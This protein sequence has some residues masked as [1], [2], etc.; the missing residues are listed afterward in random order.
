M[1]DS[2]IDKF[3]SVEN[4]INKSE[5][6]FIA[7]HINPDGDNIGSILAMGLALNSLG[8]NVNVLKTDT[9][10][11]DFNFLPG[12][13][14]IKDFKDDMDSE[15]LFIVLDSSDENRLGSLKKLLTIS[16]NVINIDH[17]I[18]NTD[19]GKINVV[20][21]LACAT[22]EIVYRLLNYMNI[23]IDKD[24]ATNIY[25]AISTDSGSFKYE[26]VTGDTH[27]IIAKLLDVGIDHSSI[28][29]NLYE[30]M[31]I[32]R[33]KLINYVLSNLNTYNDGKIAVVKVN[34]EI[35]KNTNTSME[36]TESIVSYIRKIDTVEVACILKEFEP[37]EIKV[38]LRSK[39]Y[40]D[41]SSI[42]K[43][44]DGGGHKR[45]A[46][47]KIEKNIDETEAILIKE[48]R[49]YLGD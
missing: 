5:N 6:I 15:D 12:I 22:G 23:N 13:D 16:K 17:H 4:L 32:G 44:F 31:S 46:G 20:D 29:L 35:L 40:V 47:C 1:N 19:F 30:K 7:S 49:N 18:S 3:K 48:I 34:D 26:S 27:R 39:S 43:K 14:L 37:Q 41:V 21:P 36:D 45:A 24:I 33:F 25:T 2:L 38:S 42:C 11:N 8:K 9:I 10:P 28:N